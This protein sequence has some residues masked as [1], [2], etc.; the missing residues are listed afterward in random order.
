MSAAQIWVLHIFQQNADIVWGVEPETHTFKFT[1]ILFVQASLFPARFAPDDI[2]REA[3]V[4]IVDVLL[5]HRPRLRLDLLHS[6]QPPVGD[7]M[8]TRF[9]VIGQHLRTAER[10]MGKTQTRHLRTVD[11]ANAQ[12]Q[13]EINSL[14]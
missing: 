13:T 10:H 5:H 6:L 3:A 8:P 12:N 2:F 14:C 11:I 7:K 1:S 4:D 9:A